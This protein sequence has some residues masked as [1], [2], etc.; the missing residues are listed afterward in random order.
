MKIVIPPITKRND[1]DAC[2]MECPFYSS[3]D[4]G[5]NCNIGAGA[6]DKGKKGKPA[7]FSLYPGPQC[8]G[9]GE[10]SLERIERCK[11]DKHIFVKKEDKP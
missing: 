3:S 10:Y 5:N 11:E 2:P 7:F 6:S 4:V 9:P 8:P 1:R